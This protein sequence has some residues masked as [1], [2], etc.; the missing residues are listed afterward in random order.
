MK[1]RFLLMLVHLI[2]HKPNKMILKSIL[3]ILRLSPIVLL[4]VMSPLEAQSIRLSI[5][6]KEKPSKVES[7]S[8]N[9]DQVAEQN[10]RSGNNGDL[11][12]LETVG[13]LSI[14]AKENVTLIVNTVFEE[15]LRGY[16]NKTKVS[17]EPRYI[18]NGEECPNTPSAVR[19]VS[20][21][22]KNG[23]SS[24]NINHNAKSI[25]SMPDSKEQLKAFITLIGNKEFGSTLNDNEWAEIQNQ[26]YE[27]VF[28]I[29]IEYL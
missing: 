28:T 15:V 16:D 5:E 20:K 8:F 18:N 6:V 14:T 2:Y 4:F 11:S 22:F 12:S 26:Q 10:A 21:S 25:R 13:C 19:N 9:F 27:G 1:L 29:E 23:S 24:F 17:V 7:V 3:S